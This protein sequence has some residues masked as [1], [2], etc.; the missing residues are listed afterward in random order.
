MDNRPHEKTCPDLPKDTLG[1]I[2]LAAQALKHLKNGETQQ[3]KTKFKQAR[4]WDNNVVWGDE[5]KM[6][7]SA[8]RQLLKI[9][10]LNIWY[11]AV[12]SYKTCYNDVK[13]MADY[14]NVFILTLQIPF[15]K[16]CS[17]S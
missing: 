1:A 16:I 10:L 17:N 15:L 5:G 8:F 11:P 13:R 3:A 9:Y 6:S 2:E 4:E 12:N 14:F 7:C